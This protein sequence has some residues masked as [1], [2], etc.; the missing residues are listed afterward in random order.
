MKILLVGGTGQISTAVTRLLLARGHEVAHLNRGQTTVHG[1]APVGVRTL[2]G[3]RRQFSAFEAQMQSGESWD[4]VIDMICFQPEEAESLVRA[5]RGKTRHLILTS[6][7]DVYARPQPTLP[8]RE[9]A[10]RA[11]V[12]AYG[13]A[14]VACEDIVLAAGARDGFGATV[15]RPVHTV[16]DTG[17]IHHSIGK[18]DPRLFDRYMRQLPVIVHGDGSSVW[19]ICHADDAAV[20]YAGAV[21]NTKTFG[22]AYHL[23]GPETITWSDFHR[24]AAAAIGAPAPRLIPIPTEVLHRLAPDRAAISVENFQFNN[25][26]DPTAAHADLGFAPRISFEAC[27]RRIHAHLAA[28]KLIERAETDEVYERIHAQWQ[29]HMDALV[30]GFTP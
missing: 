8:I 17:R 7:V 6:T 19:T 26:F 18:N 9:N 16:N 1:R 2:T 23:P 4:C 12:S 13:K 29:R 15:V 5:V 24:R 14:K 25:C 30:A 21:G 22:R 20:A 3:D 28:N 27:I 10:P 11:G